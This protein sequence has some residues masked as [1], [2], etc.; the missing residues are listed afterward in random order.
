L[1]DSDTRP[2]LIDASGFS[3]YHALM[4][5]PRENIMSDLNNATPHRPEDAKTHAESKAEQESKQPAPSSAKQND[6][7][8]A[9]EKTKNEALRGFH[10]G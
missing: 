7:T 8:V 6:S 1:S 2:C 3:A 5:N 4:T 10:G 9:P